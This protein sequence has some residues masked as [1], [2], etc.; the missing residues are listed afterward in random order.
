M[1][2][3]NAEASAAFPVEQCGSNVTALLVG[4]IHQVRHG[5]HFHSAKKGKKG[6]GKKGGGKGTKKAPSASK[7][8]KEATS[9]PK[10]SKASKKEGKEGKAGKAA[11]AK[12]SKAPKETKNAR[13]TG[14]GFH[15][16]TAA[17]A[18]PAEP[19]HAATSAGKRSKGH[20][21]SKRSKTAKA[22]LVGR[23]NADD[24]SKHGRRPLAVHALLAAATLASAA[25]VVVLAV[26]VALRM[27]SSCRTRG[28]EVLCEVA[29]PPTPQQVPKHKAEPLVL[30]ARSTMARSRLPPLHSQCLERHQD[31]R[32]NETAGLSPAAQEWYG[33]AA[34]AGT[35]EGGL[36]PTPLNTGPAVATRST[37]PAGSPSMRSHLHSENG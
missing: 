28:C 26:A 12:A 33:T 9:P 31:G 36:C 35:K 2:A 34:R 29:Q 3:I 6:P 22:G 27:S 16:E 8:K 10:P 15:T 1:D 13:K 14:K 37:T 18:M 30:L 17:R 5:D 24:A 25:C 7:G 11:K 19:R 32:L 4:A 21:G 23:L 20:K